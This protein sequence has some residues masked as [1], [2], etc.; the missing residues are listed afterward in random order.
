M[1]PLR[2]INDLQIWAKDS[3]YRVLSDNASIEIKLN[4]FGGV[5][6][7]SPQNEATAVT[8][9]PTLRWASYPGASEY[10]VRVWDYTGDTKGTQIVDDNT[11]NNT[12][13]ISPALSN[14]TKYLWQIAQIGPIDPISQPITVSIS[15]GST[16]EQNGTRQL[17]VSTTN[18]NQGVTW[19]SQNESIA[20]V[21][22]NG[23][24]TYVSG[25]VD[26]TVDIDATSV[27]DP[28]K[29]DTHTLTIVEES[30]YT[31]QNDRAGDE[32][33]M[34]AFY[35]STGGANWFD[36]TGW[37]DGNMSL[38][39]NP[40][41]CTIESVGGE[42]RIVS[43]DMQKI[44]T[45]PGDSEA[46]GGNDCSGTLPPEWGN[47]VECIYFNIKQ[48]DIGDTI[49]DTIQS[50]S[51]MEWISLA[52]QKLDIEIGK[53]NVAN[54]QG[55]GS[56]KAF[57]ETNS[58]SGPLPTSFSNLANPRVIEIRRQFITGTLPS[59]WSVCLTNGLKALFINHQ[60]GNNSLSGS[61]PSEWEVDNVLQNFDIS[62]GTNQATD[63]DD[64]DYGDGFS[65]TISSA[66][67]ESFK[68]TENA[69]LR[70]E[71]N[72]F[73]GASPE[74]L[75]LES[76][77][78][79]DL[80]GNAFTGSFPIKYFNQGNNSNMWLFDITDLNLSGSA[81]PDDMVPPTNPTPRDNYNVISVFRIGGNNFPG[82]LPD[83]IQEMTG[84]VQVI[85]GGLGLTGS[86]PKTLAEQPK[87]RF[88]R[89]GGNDFSGTLPDVTFTSSAFA[90]IT[91]NSMGD[92][93]GPIPES[94]GSISVGSLWRFE[95][96]DLLL[97]GNLPSWM[98]TNEDLRR[99]YLRNNRF[100]FKDFIDNN[101]YAN[102]LANIKANGGEAERFRISPQKNF[103][104]TENESVATGQ[105]FVFDYSGR[106]HSTDTKQ[107]A[108]EGSPLTDGGR[109]SGATTDTLTITN[110]EA[111]D[112]GEY[113]LELT[114]SDFD[115]NTAEGDHGALGLLVSNPINLTVT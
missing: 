51:K 34:Q 54:H 4:Y 53:E 58:F 90:D 25:A 80:S 49:P 70:L 45:D 106:S 13:T 74:F 35:D 46:S 33:F 76:I 79:I 75:N 108:K 86:F 10:K 23:L 31:P 77:R 41:G 30:S 55:I 47:L 112:A 28:T 104:D 91:M 27:E 8:T 36:N 44:K 93:T 12:Y 113:T 73:T 40:V 84:H 2:N 85:L 57:E 61:I 99:L 43:F 89:L 98:E 21:D 19:S 20:T 7:G 111:G 24:V 83:W 82:P 37:T 16:L 59:E 15:G 96:E 114:N 62:N 102:I 65:G 9:T 88:I 18:T 110:V 87:I 95:A 22:S 5:E 72:N 56:S 52:G 42:L 11:T 66:F 92:I 101:R 115:T 6:L 97:S 3:D 17:S 14:S 94:W 32:A 71:A 63:D 29:S 50:G 39:D 26:A 1:K 103:G 105:T 78:L 67:A 60:S 69:V 81:I 68:S 107:W 48:N 38:S 109:I 64:R 100:T